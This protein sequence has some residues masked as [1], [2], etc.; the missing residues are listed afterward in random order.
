MSVDSF[1][2]GGQPAI[3]LSG[4]SH[5]RVGARHAQA[6]DRGQNLQ[7]LL[8][9]GG[10]AEAKQRHHHTQ[11]ADEIGG[12]NLRVGPVRKRSFFGVFPMFVPSLSW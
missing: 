11:R 8:V 6:K 4:R 3:V 9:G 12:Q 2:G 10:G 5:L 7:H 1:I